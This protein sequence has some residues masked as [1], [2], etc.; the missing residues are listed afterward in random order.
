MSWNLG[1]EFAEE[2]FSRIRLCAATDILACRLLCE[3]QKTT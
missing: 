1:C 3:L 2:Q